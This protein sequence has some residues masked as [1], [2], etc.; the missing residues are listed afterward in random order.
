MN[1]GD[2][3]SAL[4]LLEEIDKLQTQIVLKSEK[5]CRKRLSGKV[6][7]APEEVQH[8]GKLITFWNMV[9]DKKSNKRISSKNIARKAKK[10]N[11][12]DYMIHSMNAIQRMRAT[13]W[14]DYKKVKPNA[15]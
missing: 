5:K 2:N 6:P 9:I 8:F 1:K 13:A 7:Y 4:K 3:Y 15:R 12:V 14:K 11:I 10:L